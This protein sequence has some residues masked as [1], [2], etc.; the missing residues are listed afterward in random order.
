MRKI[1]DA[2]RIPGMMPAPQLDWLAEQAS[3]HHRIVEIG[4]WRGRS[5]RALCDNCSGRVTAVDTWLGSP[6]LE[7]EILFMESVTSDPDWL[8]HEFQRNMEGI[9]N[10]EIVRKSS[11]VAANFFA[12]EQK[13]TFD[14]I[15]IDGLHDYENVKKDI[16]AWLS[17]LETGGVMAGHD[18]GFPEVRRAVLEVFPEFPVEGIADIWVV[19]K[20]APRIPK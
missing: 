6:G 12:L 5:T 20:Q 4:C 7:D 3:L 11:L 16:S 10:L 17:L 13:R 1:V 19:D 14:F 18:F 8:Y 15:F 2:D 9:T